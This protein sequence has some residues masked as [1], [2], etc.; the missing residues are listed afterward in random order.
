MLEWPRRCESNEYPQSI[1]WSKNKKKMNKK[2]GSV[3]NLLE[4]LNR[5]YGAPILAHSRIDVSGL[6]NIDEKDMKNLVF[7]F[8]Y[9]SISTCY[10]MNV[11]L[12]PFSYCDTTLKKLNLI[13]LTT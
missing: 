7:H 12:Q 5:F 2:I 9:T 1:F 8:F 3:K 6:H 10:F 13:N 11:L 4:G